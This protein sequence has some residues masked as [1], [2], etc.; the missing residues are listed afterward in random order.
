MVLDTQAHR[1]GG[2]GFMSKWIVFIAWLLAFKVVVGVGFFGQ[3]IVFGTLWR[4][5]SVSPDHNFRGD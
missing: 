1:L 5:N 4:L 3:T 2:G